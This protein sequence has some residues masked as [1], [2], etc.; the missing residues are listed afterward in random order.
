MLV[1]PAGCTDV[2]S[3]THGSLP[4]NN[5]SWDSFSIGGR[6][7]VACG[8][9]HGTVRHCALMD[10]QRI[11]AGVTTN[12]QYV[13]RP[14]GKQSVADHPGYLIEFRFDLCR[15]ENVEIVDIQNDIA[16]VGGKSLA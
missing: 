12:Q 9:I 5:V 6:K 1:L 10:L 14:L 15:F 8:A 13:R 11:H 4:Q 2:G 3:G 7:H 16:V